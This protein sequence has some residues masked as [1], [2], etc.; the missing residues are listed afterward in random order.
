MTAKINGG[1]LFLAKG[2][3]NYIK[4]RKNSATKSGMD[5]FEGFDTFS[6]PSERLEI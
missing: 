4:L 5:L 6:D 2:L 1:N 3:P